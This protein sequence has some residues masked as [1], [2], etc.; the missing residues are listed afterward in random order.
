MNIN[1]EDYE[2]LFLSELEHEYPKIFELLKKRKSFIVNGPETCG[3]L[4]IL[5]KHIEFMRLN[6]KVI[7]SDI[8][9]EYF[10]D[11][12][13]LRSKNVLSYL[14]NEN[15]NNNSDIIIL[16]NYEK[17]DEKIRD[18]M[19]K[20]T[21]I[22]FYVL[23][24]NR[25]I[26]FRYNHVKILS[27][28]FE[29]LS[30]IYLNIF[31]LELQKKKNLNA[32]LYKNLNIPYMCNFYQLKTFLYLNLNEKSNEILNISYDI[33]K[34][35]DINQIIHESNFNQKVLNVSKLNSVAIINNNLA[36]NIGCIHDIANAYE[37]ILESFNY[38]NFT[39]SNYYEIFNTLNIIAPLQYFNKSKKFDIYQTNFYV[40][41]KI[42]LNYF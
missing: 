40:K 1:L 4:T 14:E 42:K 25:Y 27:P 16:K 6:Y 5:L 19:I 21:N 37:Y 28:S 26:N 33:F 38:Y 13:T 36:Y 17:F 8:T 9:Y 34:D 29:Y 35:M 31:F 39:I 41:K 24:T 12:Y 7:E 20:N 22:N 11:N 23:I 10:K 18:Y 15:K 30:E 3:K 2:P 32:K